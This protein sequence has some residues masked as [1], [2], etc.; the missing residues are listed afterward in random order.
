MSEREIQDER[1][2]DRERECVCVRA[3]VCVVTDAMQSLIL[4]GDSVRR[5]PPQAPAV[6]EVLNTELSCGR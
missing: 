1:E 5:K 4:T 6:A 2:A 3:R